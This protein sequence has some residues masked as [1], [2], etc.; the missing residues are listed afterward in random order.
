MVLRQAMVS[1][2]IMSRHGHTAG[3]AEGSIMRRHGPKAGY[4]ERGHNE[5][6]EWAA[7]IGTPSA[8]P[9]L[10][11]ALPLPMAPPLP[12]ALPLST[13]LPLLDY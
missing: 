1:V 6:A 7:M 3:Y 12:T 11:M 8:A 13:A 10:P 5:Q 4:G 2:A 9:P